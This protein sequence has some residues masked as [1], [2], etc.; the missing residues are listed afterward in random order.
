MSENNPEVAA[1]RIGKV[2]GVTLTKWQRVWGERF[3]APLAVSDVADAEQLV[4]LRDGS[5]DMCFVRLPID[6]EGLHAIPLYEEQIVVWVSKEHPISAVDDVRLAD[7][8]DE[9]VITELNAAATDLVLGGAVL[10]VPMSIARGASRRDLTYRPI[11]DAEPAP[12]ALAWRMNDE[13]ACLEDFIGV[14]RGRTVNSSRTTQN[15]PA[16]PARGSAEND[17]GKPTRTSANRASS[18][19]GRP[20]ATKRKRRG[21]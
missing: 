21:R 8:E 7:L 6:R 10:V 18:R 20:S 16:S 5:L 13:N 17:R 3:E 2:R 1:L 12:V 9:Q 11:I 19:D 4:G 14:V 15:G